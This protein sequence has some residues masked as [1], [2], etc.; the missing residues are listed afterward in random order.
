MT[1][2]ER[3]VL[4]DSGREHDDF[5]LRV[6][7]HQRHHPR[8]SGSVLLLSHHG[9]CVQTETQHIPTGEHGRPE[10]TADSATR[11]T[12]SRSNSR[13]R[14]EEYRSVTLTFYIAFARREKP[15]IFLGV[16]LEFQARSQ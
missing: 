16:V 5:L 8:R 1:L 7:L 10:R 13:S 14:S 4:A 2:P 3:H 12:R 9:H 15:T 6:S 11:A